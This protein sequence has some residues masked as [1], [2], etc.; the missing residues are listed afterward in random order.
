MKLE[1]IKDFSRVEKILNLEFK[2][3]FKNGV[4]PDWYINTLGKM[5]FKHTLKNKTLTIVFDLIGNGD[6]SFN[7]ATYRVNEK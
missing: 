3:N 4:L 2:E 6:T 7:S 1:V 5:V